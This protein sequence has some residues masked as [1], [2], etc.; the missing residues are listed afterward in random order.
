[1]GDKADKHDKDRHDKDKPDKE[2]RDKQQLEFAG[3]ADRELVAE[4][5]N[6]LAD[7]IRLGGVTLTSPGQS[8][9]LESP[10]RLRLEVEARHRPDKGSSSIQLEVSWKA[11]RG[12]REEDEER[13]TIEPARPDS[14]ARAT[15]SLSE[16]P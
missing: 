6:R 8:V 16:R 15:A 7:G 5:L 1:M 13:L 2:K 12:A 4:Y 3:T 11:E 9:H 14:T 10:Q